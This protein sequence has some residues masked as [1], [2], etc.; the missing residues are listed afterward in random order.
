MTT[1]GKLLVFLNLVMGIGMA[2]AS[3]VVYT[4]RPT[5]FDPAPADV[6]KGNTVLTFAQ[7]KADIDTMGRAAATQSKA[8]GEGLVEIEERE[9]LR[10]R[11]RDVF[12]GPEGKDG[13]RTGGWLEIARRGDPARKDQAGFFEL[14]R[15]P[16][17]ARRG[18]GLIDHTGRGPAVIGAGGEPLRASETLLERYSAD[19]RAVTDLL[20]SIE[21]LRETQRTLGL[22][23]QWVEGRILKQIEIRDNQQTAMFYLSGFEIN[24]FSQL[25]TVRRRKAQL[26]GRLGTMGSVPKP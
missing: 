5:W 6:D 9:K 14:K 26:L 19:A 25:E 1:F 7:L 23:I 15:V 11:R 20:G 12:F 8:W 24:W 13:K 4:K 18:G 17:T 21:K 22:D 2:I 16:A 10:D 3:T